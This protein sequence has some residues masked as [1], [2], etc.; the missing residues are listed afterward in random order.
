MGCRRSPY[1]LPGHNGALRSRWGQAG[2]FTA[3]GRGAF[4][5]RSARP[6]HCGAGGGGFLTGEGVLGAGGGT[7]D[8]VQGGFG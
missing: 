1:T 4:W 6:G 3:G 7:G 8:G 2:I 5:R